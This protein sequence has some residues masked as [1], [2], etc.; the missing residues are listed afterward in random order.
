MWDMTQIQKPTYWQE[1][2]LN[3]GFDAVSGKVLLADVTIE[4]VLLL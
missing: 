1:Q 2:M 3:S 4:C